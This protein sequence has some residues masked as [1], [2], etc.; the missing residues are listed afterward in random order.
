MHV[1]VA[2]DAVDGQLGAEGAEVACCGDQSLHGEHSESD[3]LEGGLLDDFCG[4]G[5]D[6]WDM[7]VHVVRHD[8]KCGL[9][10]SVSV[11]WAS[12]SLQPCFFSSSVAGEAGLILFSISPAPMSAVLP[13]LEDIGD[14]FGT[15]CKSPRMLTTS[16]SVGPTLTS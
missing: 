12:L 3:G 10:I 2:E 11:C 4:S 14:A 1:V 5:V 13:S 7:L 8:L 6:C 16:P 9:P 15:S